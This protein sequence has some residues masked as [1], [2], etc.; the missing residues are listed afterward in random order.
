MLDVLRKSLWPSFAREGISVDSKRLNVGSRMMSLSVK[1]PVTHESLRPQVL[2]AVS[3]LT[4]DL[5]HY[6]DA[7]AKSPLD[8]QRQLRL[9]AKSGSIHKSRR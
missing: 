2:P 4:S 1:V 3:L 9:A 7:P 6:D 8:V 5:E